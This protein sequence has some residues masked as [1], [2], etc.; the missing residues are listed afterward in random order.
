MM[1]PG[2]TLLSAL[3]LAL[4]VGAA[5]ATGPSDRSVDTTVPLVLAVPG[6]EFEGPARFD[7]SVAGSAQ[8]D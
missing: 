2:P 7:N 4:N 5:A 8:A 3:L 1:K 6:S